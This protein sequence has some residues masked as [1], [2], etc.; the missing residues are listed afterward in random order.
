[1]AAQPVQTY[2]ARD[3]S[4]DWNTDLHDFEPDPL[5]ENF[6]ASLFRRGPPK[7][8]PKMYRSI[9]MVVSKNN[10]FEQVSPGQC[11]PTGNTFEL[12]PGISFNRQDIE[13][14]KRKH[15]REG[16]MVGQPYK[17]LRSKIAIP[18]PVPLLSGSLPGTKT[19]QKK[20][21][22][23]SSGKNRSPTFSLNPTSGFHPYRSPLLGRLSPKGEPS[24]RWSSLPDGSQIS[25]PGPGGQ[26]RKYKVK[27]VYYRMTRAQANIYLKSL[28]PPTGGVH[29]G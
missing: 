13:E 23:R 28:S 19:L 11:Q 2:L 12:F 9:P 1:M 29:W 15:S 27:Y 16:H 24:L 17:G 4:F 8:S 26:Q 22:E 18:Y 25:L 5:A 10:S 6:E 21:P 14:T 20:V 3:L 7:N